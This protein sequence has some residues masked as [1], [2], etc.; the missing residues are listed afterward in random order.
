MNL[1]GLLLLAA[2]GTSS[3]SPAMTAQTLHLSVQL[4][5]QILDYEVPGHPHTVGQSQVGFVLRPVLVYEYDR[6]LRLEAGA[7]LRWAFAQ[8]FDAELGAFPHAAIVL[9]PFGPELSLRLGSLDIHHGFHPAVV[10]E[11]RYA[12]GRDYERSYNRS[13]VPAAQRDLGGD[14]FMPVENGAQL[15]AAAGDFRGEIYLDWQLID[16]R[17]HREKFALGLLGEYRGRWLDLGVQYRV[18]HYGGQE[19]TAVDPLRSGGLDP[20]RQ[21]STLAVNL[22]LKP[23]RLGPTALELPISFLH[24]RMIQRPGEDSRIHFG[25]EPGIDFIALDMLRLGYRLWLPNGD[26]ARFLSEDGDPVY[27]GP[28][29]HRIVFESR[30]SFGVVDLLGRLD[31]VVPKGSS[32]V[33][34]LSLFF[35]E[36][37]LEPELWSTRR[38]P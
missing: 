8:D 23:L 10:D 28:L 19:F 22:R 7:V 31:L 4:R 20:K 17:E 13:L 21:P 30:L 36:V 6:H 14:P 3:A 25:L 12:Y 37:H 1:A 38:L 24:G 18:V 15:I 34:T 27:S 11:T 35:A 33:Q 5:P 26:E 9:T 29:A 32:T 2:V 16:T